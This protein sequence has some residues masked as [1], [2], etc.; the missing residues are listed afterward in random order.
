MAGSER[1]DA[2]SE[3]TALVSDFRPTFRLDGPG[4]ADMR[5][6]LD[7]NSRGR[8]PPMEVYAWGVLLLVCLA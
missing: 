6:I 8:E 4:R 5:S 2:A 1:T 7:M 3:A